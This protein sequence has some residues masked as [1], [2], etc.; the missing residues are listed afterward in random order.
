VPQVKLKLRHKDHLNPA[1]GLIYDISKPNHRGVEGGVLDLHPAIGEEEMGEDEVDIMVRWMEDIPTDR[2]GLRVDNHHLINIMD[3]GIIYSIDLKLL[4]VYMDWR[5]LRLIKWMLGGGN[6]PRGVTG[7]GA[8]ERGMDQLRPTARRIRLQSLTLVHLL[9]NHSPHL[10]RLKSALKS[11]TMPVRSLN[12]GKLDLNPNPD[13]HA[14]PKRPMY[15]VPPPHPHQSTLDH[16][17]EQH[18]TK[19][20]NSPKPFLPL[21]PAPT[22]KRNSNRKKRGQLPKRMI[23]LIDLLVDWERDHFLNAPFVIIQLYPLNRFGVVSHPIL[24]PLRHSQWV[25]MWL[26]Q[27]SLRVIIK[28]VIPLFIIT[29]LRIGVGGTM[30]RIKRD[31]GWLIVRKKLFGGVLG[32]R[33]GERIGFLH[34]GMSQPADLCGI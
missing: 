16:P 11:K 12:E 17:A 24:H 7:L 8:G 30:R 3:M 5:K 2:M 10:I 29:V 18:S 19:V 14:P 25:L 34:T 33:R 13:K 23:S 9:S 20:L 4:R 26:I 31:W 21:L 22:R 15:H 28:L 27:K 1:T 6:R 32:V